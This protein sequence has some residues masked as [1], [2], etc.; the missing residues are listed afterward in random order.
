VFDKKDNISFPQ[1]GWYTQNMSILAAAYPAKPAKTREAKRVAWVYAALLAIMF[2]AQVVTFQ[3]FVLV[4]ESY[5]LPG[6][7][8]FYAFLAGLLIFSELLSLAFLLRLKLSPAFRI[9]TMA[10][11]WLVPIIWTVLT[12]SAVVSNSS[13]T[14]VGFLGDLVPLVPGW[15]AV[16]VSLALMIM[17][18]WVSWGLWPFPIT[19][20]K[21]K[22]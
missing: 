21:H 11:S 14:N 20:P 8:Q 22:K 19:R 7:A 16:F 4:L 9:F 1:S 13:L 2:I 6:S 15:W 5:G 17:A 3:R 10:L 12:F 18:A